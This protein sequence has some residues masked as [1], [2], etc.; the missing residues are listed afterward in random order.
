MAIFSVSSRASSEAM[1]QSRNEN[2]YRI[3]DRQG[4]H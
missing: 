1:R 4:Q 2:S 3:T